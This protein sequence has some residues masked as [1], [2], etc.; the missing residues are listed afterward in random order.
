MLPRQRQCDQVDHP[1][2]MNPR[3]TSRVRPRALQRHR[4]L[5]GP[6]GWSHPGH[7]DDD[8]DA[9]RRDEWHGNESLIRDGDV[10]PH[11]LRQHRATGDGQHRNYPHHPVGPSET[12]RL[13][14]LQPDPRRVGIWPTRTRTSLWTNEGVIPESINAV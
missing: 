11:L 7:A 6:H 14:G 3:D 12:W 2:N 4:A 1:A 9:I 5:E 8:F 10:C 13:P